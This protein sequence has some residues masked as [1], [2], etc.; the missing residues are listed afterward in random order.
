M[1]MGL[2]EAKVGFTLLLIFGAGVFS[3]VMLDRQFTPRPEETARKRG[4]P[5]S[6][7]DD[8]V[9]SELRT[10]VGITPEQETKISAILTNWGEQLQQHHQTTLKERFELFE[11]TMPTVRSNLTA[12]QARKF[13]AIMERIRRQQRAMLNRAN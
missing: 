7:R 9:L 8:F 10:K 5:L 11:K 12:E 4:V 13:D 2:R 1:R 6:K 3:G